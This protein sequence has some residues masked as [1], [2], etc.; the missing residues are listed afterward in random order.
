M[1]IDTFVFQPDTSPIVYTAV[2]WPS[3]AV[4]CLQGKAA[5][6]NL[7]HLGA[8]NAT[9]WVLVVPRDVPLQIN[10]ASAVALDPVSLSPTLLV[11]VQP[12]TYFTG[13]LEFEIRI[14]SQRGQRTVIDPY[15]VIVDVTPL[16]VP[17]M[18]QVVT[19]NTSVTFGDVA[20][21][22][23]V[24]VPLSTTTAF[25]IEI[26]VLNA[27]MASSLVA[28]QVV[29]LETISQFPAEY[30]YANM[31]SATAWRWTLPV[32]V[33]PSGTVADRH[34]VSLSVAV[35]MA[36][37]FAGHVPLALRLVSFLAAN[38]SVTAEWVYQQTVQWH[39]NQVPLVEV[40]PLWTVTTLEN[41]DTSVAWIAILTQPMLTGTYWT[42]AYNLTGMSLQYGVNQTVQ[43]ASVNTLFDISQSITAVRASKVLAVSVN[44]SMS[45]IMSDDAVQL[46]VLPYRYGSIDVTLNF[47]FY[48][49]DESIRP[50]ILMQPIQLDVL[51]V[52]QQPVIDFVRS[53]AVV[54]SGDVADVTVQIASPILD[55]SDTLTALLWTDTPM[56]LVQNASNDALE[57]HQ[58]ETLLRYGI[59][60]GTS[61][62]QSIQAWSADFRVAA[63]GNFSGRS[64]F[65]LEIRAI[66]TTNTT[67][68]ASVFH[69]FAID[70]APSDT[71]IVVP[72]S[73]VSMTTFGGEIWTLDAPALLHQ[74]HAQLP[75]P[76]ATSAIA[77]ALYAYTLVTAN[78]DWL[79]LD[80][81]NWTRPTSPYVVYTSRDADAPVLSLIPSNASSAIV[82][83][84]EI[85]YGFA[86]VVP[87]I[88]APVR[89]VLAVA[90]VPSLAPNLVRVQAANIT[91]YD[92]PNSINLT[93]ECAK[94]VVHFE[95]TTLAYL[96]N[97]RSVQDTAVLNIGTAIQ[98]VAWPPLASNFSGVVPFQ[99]SA[100]CDHGPALSVRKD[101]RWLANPASFRLSPTA[102]NASTDENTWLQLALG[103]ILS[104]TNRTV[105][106][107]RYRVVALRYVTPLDG[108]IQRVEFDNATLLDSTS[109]GLLPRAQFSGI[110]SITWLIEYE[111]VDT[112]FGQVVALQNQTATHTIR[113]VVHPVAVAPALDLATDGVV[114]F[115]NYSR[116]TLH[117]TIGGDT[118]QTTQLYLS[119]TGRI[120][121][122]SGGLWMP[123]FGS[124]RLGTL[125]LNTTLQWVYAPSQP[126]VSVVDCTLHS[127]TTS[128][129]LGL[130]TDPRQMLA[131]Q[132]INWTTAWQP[133]VHVPV[134]PVQSL[135]FT[136]VVNRSL[137]LSLPDLISALPNA[138]SCA[139]QWYTSDVQRILTDGVVVNAT[140]TSQ[141][142]PK[143]AQASGIPCA[144]LSQLTIAFTPSYVGRTALLLDIGTLAAQYPV[145]ITVVVK[146]MPIAPHV[147]LS[148]NAVV[149]SYEQPVTLVAYAPAPPGTLVTY[150][151]VSS[152]PVITAIGRNDLWF[153]ADNAGIISMRPWAAVDVTL[154]VLAPLGYVGSVL[155]TLT[156]L[157]QNGGDVAF[158][159]QE[160]N[161]TWLRALPPLLEVSSVSSMY[162]TDM[163]SIQLQTSLQHQDSAVGA[164]RVLMTTSQALQNV[165]RT[166]IA[167]PVAYNIQ[168]PA[169]ELVVTPLRYFG[170]PIV[171]TFQATSTA[172]GTSAISVASLNVTV[173]PVVST[174]N[175]TLGVPA[176][177]QNTSSILSIQVARVEPLGYTEVSKS[178]LVF[179]N[180]GIDAVKDAVT[181][182]SVPCV[183]VGPNVTACPLASTFGAARN[184]SLVLTPY[185]DYAGPVNF[186]VLTIH[187]I[188]EAP[189]D[190]ME[191]AWNSSMLQTCC[192]NIA[193]Q[194]TA[195]SSAG[196]LMVRGIA[197]YPN[198][199]VSHTSL[200]SSVQAISAVKVFALDV[201]DPF[202]LQLLTAAIVCPSNTLQRVIVSQNY[203]RTNM[204][205]GALANATAV[206]VYSLAWLPRIAPWG[207]ELVWA[208]NVT[209][210]RFN[211]TLV[212]QSRSILFPNS[213]VTT[214][215]T[216][217]VE[218]NSTPPALT[219][220]QAYIEVPEGQ[221]IVLAASLAT[222]NATLILEAPLAV[223]QRVAFQ[224]ASMLLGTTAQLG[225]RTY[226]YGGA[227]GIRGA[228][229][230]TT[231]PTSGDV[232]LRLFSFPTATTAT[233]VWNAT[234]ATQVLVQINP[235]PMLPLLY[236]S[237]SVLFVPTSHTN[238]T[239]NVAVSMAHV[240]VENVVFLQVGVPRFLVTDVR[241]NGQLQVPRAVNATTLLYQINESSALTSGSMTLSVQ[242]YY[243]GHF[244]VTLDAFSVVPALGLMASN[245][246]Y[247]SVVAFAST[248][249]ATKLVVAPSVE[250]RATDFIEV[251]VTSNV[252]DLVLLDL[253][254]RYLG[255]VVAN[256]LVLPRTAWGNSSIPSY[257]LPQPLTQLY[258][259]SRP[260]FAG[261]FT[262]ALVGVDAS[263]A[264]GVAPV[265]V[266]AQPVALPPRLLL[267]SAVIVNATTVYLDV[268][269]DVPSPSNGVDV[270]ALSM[271]MPVSVP[272]AACSVPSQ[273]SVP[274][275]VNGTF[276]TFDIPFTTTTVRFVLAPNYVG[277]FSVAVLLTD[278]SGLVS[279]ASVETMIDLVI[280]P[281]AAPPAVAWTYALSS[282]FSS[283]SVVNNAL[284][285]SS[286]LN[287]TSLS[288]VSSAWNT[289]GNGNISST[290]TITTIASVT[291]SLQSSITFNGSETWLAFVPT[292]SV[293]D[294]SELEI[295]SDAPRL[296]SSRAVPSDYIGSYVVL[297]PPQVW[298][299]P[300]MYGA[301]TTLLGATTASL[302]QATGVS[303]QTTSQSSRVVA[304]AVRITPAAQVPTVALQLPSPIDG[305]GP[306][307][308]YEADP[309]G[310]AITATTAYAVPTQVLQIRLSVSNSQLSN[311]SINGTVLALP[312]TGPVV[313]P[314]TL[315]ANV[316][317]LTT[318]SLPVVRGVFGLL[319]MQL[320][321]QNTETL[322]ND[323]QLV[324]Q[325]WNVTVV[326]VAHVPILVVRPSATTLRESDVL[327][328]MATATALST[329]ENISISVASSPME[330][331]LTLQFRGGT[332]SFLPSGANV[333]LSLAKYWFG[334]LQLNVTA[335]AQQSMASPR[336][337]ASNSQLL[338]ISVLPVA[339]PPLLV[340]NQSQYGVM[341][342]WVTVPINISA[343]VVNRS[344]GIDEWTLNLVARA[345]ALNV[346]A[347]Q[348][349]LTRNASLSNITLDF[350]TLP[351]SGEVSVQPT[352]A[353]GGVYVIGL[354]STDRV[355]VSRTNATTVQRSTLYIAGIRVSANATSMDQG[356]SVLFTV[357]VNSPPVAPV[358]I[359]L[360]CNDTS[361]LVVPVP[362]VATTNTTLQWLLRSTRDFMDN[363][364][365]FVNCAMV[366]NT[367][368][369]Y[370]QQVPLPN[371][372]LVL[373]NKDTSGF[374]LRGTMLNNKVQLTVAE[375][376]FPDS[377]TVA[378][379]SKPFDE[380]DIF[381]TSNVSNLRTTPPLLV[382]TQD[383]WN[384]PQTVVANA[385]KVSNIIGTV[386]AS[387][388]HTVVTN[389]TKYAALQNF[390]VG[391]S[392]LVT[393]D[394]TPPPSLQSA[395]FGNTGADILLTFSR[396][397][398]LSSFP[399]PASFVC[400]RLLVFTTGFYG[401]V[402]TCGW[403]SKSSVRILL[404]KSPTV[405]PGDKS[406][407]IAGLKATA[408]S[409]LTMPTSYI[410]IQTPANPPV[411][412]VSVTGPQNLGS[413]DDLVLD[414]RSSSG[415]GGRAMA[416]VWTIANAPDIAT[417]LLA[418]GTTAQT[419]SLPASTFIA[420]GTYTFSL[421]ITNFFG[422]SGTSGSI[423][424]TKASTPLPVVSIDGPSTVSLTKSSTLALNS[425]AT[426]ATCGNT[427]VSSI[428][429]SFQ[430]SMI[431]S[432][433]VVTVV[434]STSRNPRQLRLPL[435]TIAYGTYTV[436]VL[437][438]VFG[439]PAQINSAS[440]TLQ[441]VPSALVAVIS[442][443]FRTVG[444]Q[445]D[446]VLSGTSSNDPDAST[447]AL[448]YAW[449]CV[450][451]TT[452]AVSCGNVAIT[453]GST[454]AVAKA[455]LPP[456]TTIR[457]LLTV[458]D[459]ATQRSAQASTTYTVLLGSPPKTTVAPLSQ[460]KYNPDTKIVLNGAVT[461]A[462][463]TSP[464]ALWSVQG[465]TT[466]ATAAFG[467]ARTSLTM[468]LLPN[469]LT[470]GKTYVF[471]LTGTDKF[472]QSSNAT[473]SVQ[474]NEPPT[475]GLLLSSPTSGTT[476]AT[477]FALSSLNWVD[478]D[479][480]LTYAFKYIVG[481][482]SA[483]ATEIALGDYALST[484][485]TTVFPLGGGANSTITI[486]AYVADAYGYATKV[487]S[488]IVVAAPTGSA[489]AQQTA[490]S[491][492]SS[493]L[494]SSAASTDPGQVVN[495]V[496]ML[497]SML[498]PTTT[499]STGSGSSGSTTT[500][501]PTAS[502]APG[503]TPAPTVL[504]LK[505]CPSSST[506]AVCSGHGTCVL[507]PP[508]CPVTNID[509]TATCTCDT[510]WYNTDC[511][512]SQADYDQKQA[513]L[514]NLLTAMT[515][516][517]S[518][519]EPTAKAVEQQTSAVQSITA[520]SGLLSPTQ[521]TQA[522]DLVA[523]V[524]SA[525]S[526]VQLSTA[527]TT[528]VGS[529]ISNLLDASS[530][531]TSS[532][533]RLTGATNSS[534]DA[535]AK[536][537]KVQST[538][539]LLASAMLNGIV[540][541]EEAVQMNSKNVKMVLQRHDPANLNG[542]LELPL[543]ASQVQAN[544]S[545]QTF[546][547]PTNL[548]ASSACAQAVDTH[549]TFLAQNVYQY[550]NASSNINSG[551]IGLKLLCD[552][553]S[554]PLAVANLTSGIS[555]RMRKLA[556]YPVPGAPT[557][558]NVSCAAG[559]PVHFN[560][561][562]SVE[563][564]L[565]KLVACNGSANY[566]VQYTC[567][568]YI[569]TPKCQYWD[570]A[571]GA[572]STA[573]CKQLPDP[574]DNY[575]LCVCDHLTD[576]STQVDMALQAVEDNFFSVIEHQT[577][578]ED[579][580]QNIGVVITMGVM[581][582]LYGV[583]LL[584]C[585]KWDR[586]DRA[587]R[588]KY[589]LT[590]S[591]EPK[592]IDLRSLFELPKVVAAKTRREKARA[593]LSGFWDG[594]KANHRILSTIMQYDETFTRPQRA[595]I[596][597]TVTMSQM[598]I[599]A[600]LYKL[601]QMDPNIGTV[602][603]SGL[604]SS[605]CM[606]PV[607]LA[608][609]ILFRKA[610]K[611]HDYTVRYEI[612]DDDH[613]VE[614]E[615]DAYGKPVQ[616]S[617]YDMLCMDLQGLLNAV[618]HGAYARMLARLER[619]PNLT[620]LAS[621]VSQSLYL[622]LNNRE[623]RE[624]EP[625]DDITVELVPKNTSRS[626][627]SF[628]SK[629]K[630]VLPATGS[631]ANVPVE[632]DPSLLSVE[633][634]VDKLLALWSPHADV[635]GRLNKFEPTAIVSSTRSKL[636]YLL[637]QAIELQK[638]ETSRA[639]TAE[640]D[641]LASVASILAWCRKCYECAE[642]FADDT[643]AVLRHAKHE[644]QRTRE[645]L[646]MTRRMVQK[647]LRDR[648]QHFRSNMY[649]APRDASGSLRHGSLK[650]HKKVVLQSV[651]N[652]VQVV[653]QKTRHHMT[654]TQR[655]LQDAR[656][657]SRVD[658]KLKTKEAKKQMTEILGSL[659]GLARW[660]KRFE[661][662][663]EAK[664][665][666]LVDA[667]PL[668]ERQ[669]YLN[670]SEKLKKLRFG[671]R[672]MYNL[673][674]RKA[675][676][677][678][679]KPIFPEFVNY[680]L[681]AM[682]TG[683]D[684]FT[685]YF[686]LQFSFT[687]GHV[688][689]SMW[690]G[691]LFTGLAM[692]YLVSDPLHIFLRVGVLPLV[693]SIFLVNTGL[694]E[695]LGTEI[696]AVGAAA[697]V[698]IAGV[699]KFREK[700]AARLLPVGVVEGPSAQ[701]AS[702]DAPPVLA[703]A[704]S[705]RLVLEVPPVASE[706]VVASIVSEPVPAPVV[707]EPVVTPAGVSVVSDTITVPAA[708]RPATT[709]VESVP[710][711]SPIVD[712]T[713]A[714]MASFKSLPKVIN[715]S[716]RPAPS[717]ATASATKPLLAGP[718]MA[719]LPALAATVQDTTSDA[720]SSIRAADPVVVA[721][722]L[723]AELATPVPLVESFVC[724]CGA[725]MLPDEHVH[726][727]EHDCSHRLVQCRA[728]CGVYIQLRARSSHE[729]SQCRL[730][731]CACGKMVLR[732]KMTTHLETECALR[733]VTC[734]LGCGASMPLNARE[735]H[736]RSECDL[737]V[738][739]CPDCNTVLPVRELAT[740]RATCKTK[741]VVRGPATKL[742]VT[743]SSMLTLGEDAL[744]EPSAQRPV[745][746][747]SP[748]TSRL[749]GPP[750]AIPTTKAPRGPLVPPTTSPVARRARA[751]PVATATPGVLQGPPL[752]LAP[753]AI[754]D[755]AKT[756]DDLARKG[757][758]MTAAAEG[759][760][761]LTNESDAKPR[762]ADV[763]EALVEKTGAGQMAKSAFEGA[764]TT[765]FEGTVPARTQPL[766]GPRTA[767]PFQ[768]PSDAKPST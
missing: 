528:A 540:P 261:F 362:L 364:N 488:E 59:P 542:A 577:T 232:L 123:F 546:T 133:S 471:V 39:Y 356:T 451:A 501:A 43:N 243:D 45:E 350:F 657:K 273:A 226:V 25:A 612:E 72:A 162:A 367:T 447:T 285:A 169:N 628:F 372:S 629:P 686:I 694:F 557:S 264:L 311:V 171:W 380:V 293:T 259:Q 359:S 143:F 412:K 40:A 715:V 581:I 233:N 246:S 37:D 527:A 68:R 42:Q 333:T 86:S 103:S 419:V 148:T 410:A 625:L 468:L 454:T 18:P 482:A 256:G 134:M 10:R 56:L 619:D 443:G 764:A 48:G 411:P 516:A 464:T 617:K 689:A 500:P 435:R 521:Q 200:V 590:K 551:I 533:R 335:L 572:W 383:N 434:S 62:R 31:T 512:T 352:T 751:P 279:T 721:A 175:V 660:K 27:T 58:N 655:R 677:R 382:F 589:A 682:C 644:M 597:F 90:G 388:V 763:A 207:L 301:M 616:Y 220:P 514:G 297:P 198:V 325:S 294:L 387:I 281:R 681:Y 46:H 709:I 323:S 672:L 349:L 347:N 374:A 240:D 529:S 194:C 106:D 363:G 290:G 556:Q 429:L 351:V 543:S 653:I 729:M 82:L 206:D 71:P 21:V 422:A 691:S 168:L 701:L 64:S 651:H 303:L 635:Y 51:Q 317:P 44:V 121:A 504:V 470:A 274:M 23:M 737:R 308:V 466:F 146:S 32:V 300:Y 85:H 591:N 761:R 341:G 537:I 13:R 432:S 399:T 599:N 127:M 654:E 727:R 553:S 463:D 730:L 633:S 754:V 193:S 446:L 459:P 135:S 373:V 438:G 767:N 66:A 57:T 765:L 209:T 63:V 663:Q 674:L 144:N 205:K 12:P 188:L 219:L 140:R 305:Y 452:G 588:L 355:A 230:L 702:A 54:A 506:S 503:A 748:T 578:V 316:L 87:R 105:N 688:V 520:N 606:M 675:P 190:C 474:I 398:D 627:F 646:V 136:T 286:L 630:V 5:T 7:T 402:P 33:L 386:P 50:R 693:A 36:P 668:H 238:V 309:V 94:A 700:K 685:A 508:R 495:L 255:K 639:S 421:T 671:A 445:E 110:L 30:H 282:Q 241:W 718:S 637:Q 640:V 173:V 722:A 104:V 28:A 179:S 746:P 41:V 354:H 408:T 34:L 343:L 624:P 277:T 626:H 579:V 268:V 145:A 320:S 215:T 749:Q 73:I 237:P 525:S 489:A 486:V 439:Q 596:I 329:T 77:S 431:Q 227:S 476:L 152:P 465:D 433:G 747:P 741:A 716:P 328:L 511:A 502:V 397:V 547:L 742:L 669:R 203:T 608:F 583:S 236:A 158:D 401:D 99:V 187:S 252:S 719:A 222:A 272:V 314:S 163:A 636:G 129:D 253:E 758:A 125:N 334:S 706:P 728:G 725:S 656:R 699:A 138:T 29:A 544:Y 166:L 406:Q 22:T 270:L 462:I 313:F 507:N 336:D 331:A 278:T 151:I 288:N 346:W 212:A 705:A 752:V 137:V 484:S 119:C 545:K 337:K 96:V 384:V 321:V 8:L 97:G 208:T 631:P 55:G 613:I 16:P 19:C 53:P 461:S 667:M 680:I 338:N 490:L 221:P 478:V 353:H 49:A 575:M 117:V 585:L 141:L 65:C 191:Q 570:S 607:T 61:F 345:G 481:P 157:V 60:F 573:G 102:A 569:P 80:S 531:T 197:A 564:Q 199:S 358:T 430:W 14:C 370:Y 469:T 70:F 734:R 126:T 538:V 427:D 265:R 283:P 497:A 100:L 594:L 703:P 561:T 710:Q 757:V 487:Y 513:M 239:T 499:S 647:Q 155:L 659:H 113:V 385:S 88:V 120:V 98:V 224:N 365:N 263:L 130:G 271:T 673:F 467:F 704:P 393:S 76:Y 711:P 75:L 204:T 519:I 649:A 244:S 510:S 310:F 736:E 275:R 530:T 642:C 733:S 248:L 391:V 670:E 390:T 260:G 683:I 740:H 450:D 211:C 664:E 620:S 156:A 678:L 318:V 558:G 132:S 621:I 95:P 247:L 535:A 93:L 172:F 409:T 496:G 650:D 122:Y 760:K 552:Y 161:V 229:V 319:P 477:S 378:L 658:H 189:R 541:G 225:N 491:D 291:R 177:V 149:A 280:A 696:V 357:A 480:P 414:G 181:N 112:Q 369:V 315:P 142:P 20:V 366:I 648:L 377:Y 603:V 368:D 379:T 550:A 299:N 441:V 413:C 539:G 600:L 684:A 6:F 679:E 324:I 717:S 147:R 254:Q 695:A 312:K 665:K 610:G 498:K 724:E 9:Q 2:I 416:W 284:N 115:G 228:F 768:P 479:L 407:V 753:G 38:A 250:G 150:H 371:T 576:F 472:G 217:V 598:F 492:Q 307:A 74:T 457:I 560:I 381:M 473:I 580:V 707:P 167:S 726:H 101:L 428:A 418:L 571:A 493:L 392:L 287:A 332:L 731:L 192:D 109:I 257:T 400:T 420:G 214:N 111:G 515:S 330:A 267:V 426:P 235:L 714:P 643:N 618:P 396:D 183:V 593:L 666:K 81:G 602:I 210:M 159:A 744:A 509:C 494:A 444:N 534:A 518:T 743:Q 128:V 595:M 114:D 79:R 292:V 586:D 15:L 456:T 375:G 559:P 732:T 405:L 245:R 442:N 460:L 154:Q 708:S 296:L 562:C 532:R 582:I 548:P 322:N 417:T 453:N 455:N 622:I 69:R 339:Y 1:A 92:Q 720:A 184:F 289:S 632:D 180:F 623:V 182:T 756:K 342:T 745:S 78:I 424:V 302:H 712:D 449:Q 458:Y 697:A 298:T 223:I 304:V 762:R 327:Q 395:Q 124:V 759:A 555:I 568:Q 436:Q 213:T 605:V 690:I 3:M 425:V 47:T 565:Y 536:A 567:P 592:H 415:G 423:V 584:F 360:A 641:E 91:A 483:G 403:T 750:L 755:E 566:T 201:R 713:T 84:M 723:T 242:S 295:G 131:T 185:L 218:L 524:L 231:F 196:T 107:I 116:A 404:G 153:T 195:T 634:A 249:D 89:V 348:T 164:L 440:V 139:F 662:Y 523:S 118:S 52:A 306:W 554:T 266:H 687:V 517:A 549:A 216:F 26:E 615:V 526:Q 202:R 661:L 108:N 276:Q 563:Q 174:P 160:L 738:T 361:R 437:V 83:D 170:G 234:L 344:S 485:F 739:S 604:V 67:S 17:P 258:V 165:T 269:S 676:Q 601:R 609:V 340:V 448:L 505:S 475:S 766:R 11:H 692:T 394:T 262:V 645:Q 376:G 638:K 611:M 186:S 735:K 698:G 251:P 587:K 24:N 4:A 614:V 326:P 389:D 178:M 35:Q 652:Q 522:L 574:D 176:M